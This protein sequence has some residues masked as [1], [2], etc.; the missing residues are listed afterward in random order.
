MILIKSWNS[1]SA[2]PFI[3]QDKLRGSWRKRLIPFSWLHDQA[4][5]ILLHTN[6]VCLRVGPLWHEGIFY[7]CCG[8]CGRVITS[9]RQS[10]CFNPW[11]LVVFT[12][13]HVPGEN[14][15]AELLPKLLLWCANVFNWLFLLKIPAYWQNVKGRQN[16]TLIFTLKLELAVLNLLSRFECSLFTNHPLESLTKDYPPTNVHN[17]GSHIGSLHILVEAISC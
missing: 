6:K 8:S 15:N 1:I 2:P 17:C 10:S 13:Y 5:H 3:F 11:P 16:S 14:L 9:V 7:S 4:S 12:S